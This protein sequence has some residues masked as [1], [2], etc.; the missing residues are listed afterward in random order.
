VLGALRAGWRARA[1]NAVDIQPPAGVHL[2]E[3]QVAPAHRN[4]GLGSHLLAEVERTARRQHAPKLSLTTA[5]D[6]PPAA[7]RTPRVPRRGREARPALRGDHRQP[8]PRLD[9]QDTRHLRPRRPG[10]DARPPDQISASPV[11]DEHLA[12][13]VPRADERDARVIS[14]DAILA[15]EIIEVRSSGC[16]SAR[17]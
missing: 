12:G 13:G 8:G 15:A 2:V 9:G 4:A 3:L 6:T 1:R 16:T 7:V 14:G 5:I 11:D 17:H 10:I